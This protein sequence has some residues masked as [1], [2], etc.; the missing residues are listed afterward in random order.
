MKMHF[1]E[2]QN[3]RIPQFIA[4]NTLNSLKEIIYYSVLLSFTVP[5]CYKL[6]SMGEKTSST[7]VIIPTTPT[8]TDDSLPV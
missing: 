4:S 1:H 5:D 7:T 3:S 8:T 6:V 2:H